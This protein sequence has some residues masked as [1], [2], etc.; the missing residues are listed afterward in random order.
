MSKDEAVLHW[1]LS[2][3]PNGTWQAVRKGNKRAT[4]V[5][6]TYQEAYDRIHQ[7]IVEA[8]KGLKAED[9]RGEIH[10]PAEKVELSASCPCGTESEWSI[11][12]NARPPASYII[13]LRNA[14]GTQ[15]KAEY[16]KCTQCGRPLTPDYVSLQEG[17]ELTF[18]DVCAVLRD[19]AS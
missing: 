17:L 5:C 8:F 10:T 15:C 6:G 14:D 11:M 16:C 9:Q 3:R 13:Y 12:Y 2:R 19:A 4:L 7:I 1:N 18:K